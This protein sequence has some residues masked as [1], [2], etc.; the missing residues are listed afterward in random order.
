MA[1]LTPQFCTN[2]T[3]REYTTLYYL[4]AATNYR[5]RAA[6]NGAWGSQMIKWRQLLNEK[7]PGIRFGES[8]ISTGEQVHTFDTQ[9]YLNGLDPAMVLV[10]IYANGLNGGA[11]VRQPMTCLRTLAGA[12]SGFV[13][14]AQVSGTRPASDYTP[15]MIPHLDGIAVPLEA[16]EIIWQ[17]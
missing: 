8:R 7:W 5:A 17:R 9:V 12:V 11:P 4:P 16:D 10:E 1:R 14:Q 13:Y 2:R 3:V 15:R 6:N